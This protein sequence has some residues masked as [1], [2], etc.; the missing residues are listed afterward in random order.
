MLT[1]Q[2]DTYDKDLWLNQRVVLVHLGM[3]S[4]EENRMLSAMLTNL[5]KVIAENIGD[6]KRPV[7]LMLDELRHHAKV[8]K[9]SILEV[10]STGRSRSLWLLAATQT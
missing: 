5:L 4:A 6:W 1:A 7:I 2:R 10:Q 3:R 8:I 9:D